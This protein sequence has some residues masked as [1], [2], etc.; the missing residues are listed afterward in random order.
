[1]RQKS[2]N[3]LSRAAVAV[4]ATLVVGTVAAG[5]YFSG[6][7][8]PSAVTSS[9]NSSTTIASSSSQL[10]H[11]TS[12]HSGV[13]TTTLSQTTTYSSISTG[14][15]STIT[16]AG[17]TLPNVLFGLCSGTHTF[18]VL[19][20]YTL[21]WTTFTVN[22][23]E[24]VE[25]GTVSVFPTPQNYNTTVAAL[26]YVDGSLIASGGSPIPPPVS[27]NGSSPAIFQVGA[28]VL[29]NSTIAAGSQVSLAL[30]SPTPINVTVNFVSPQTY[31]SP[32]STLP[33]HSDML[34]SVSG[35]STLSYAPDFCSYNFQSTG[36]A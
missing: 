30:W 34:P 17:D 19:P 18:E 3:A 25:A 23:T 8:Y 2:R 29:I 35:A 28:S 20:A 32:V 27:I 14:S 7:V 11:S 12:S 15:Q 16:I 5:L 22:T 36:W 33:R 31:S 13:A 1:M 9:T 21:V 26:A 4:F 24:Y 6:A 10:I